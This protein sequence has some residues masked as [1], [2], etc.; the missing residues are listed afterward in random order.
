LFLSSNG[1]AK[2]C[3]KICRGHPTTLR[4]SAED[5]CQGARVSAQAQEVC[6]Q[7]HEIS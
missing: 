5:L 7:A 3:L 2:K 4:P 1:T 6:T